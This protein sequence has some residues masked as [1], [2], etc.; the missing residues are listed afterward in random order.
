MDGEL[1]SRWT[2]DALARDLAIEVSNCEMAMFID[3]RDGSILSRRFI[4]DCGGA[5]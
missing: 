3:Y 2:S 4:M 5:H 1:K